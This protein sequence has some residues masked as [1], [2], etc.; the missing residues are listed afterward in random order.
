MELIE[1]YVW[2]I[3]GVKHVKD[4]VYTAQ[5]YSEEQAQHLMHYWRAQYSDRTLICMP[6]DEGLQYFDRFDFGIVMRLLPNNFRVTRSSWENEYLEM[7]RNGIFCLEAGTEGAYE[8]PKG[9]P[10]LPKMEDLMATD[11]QVLRRD[12]QA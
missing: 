6:P 12:N 3:N 11:W 2:K 8:E 5:I 10:W 4:G 9:G 1:S 7:R